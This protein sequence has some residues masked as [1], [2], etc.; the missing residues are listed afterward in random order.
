MGVSL[1][2]ICG[3]YRG[4]ARVRAGREAELSPQERKQLQK[5]AAE[6]LLE[7]SANGRFTKQVTEGTWSLE[8]KRILFT[9]EKFGGKTLA[10]MQEAA[11]ANGRS[12]GLAFVFNSFELR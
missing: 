1:S 6:N 12:F 9:P 10:E 7:I 4:E 5:G 11:E 8:A 2:S 3:K